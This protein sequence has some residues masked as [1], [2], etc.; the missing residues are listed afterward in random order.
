MWPTYA[1][2]LNANNQGHPGTGNERIFY[3]LLQAYKTKE[4][5]KYDIVIVQWSGHNRFDYLTKHGWTESDGAI[6]LS[7]KNKHLWRNLKS[8]YNTDYELEK[9]MNYVISADAILKQLPIKK[10][11]TSMN[12][13]KTD[14]IDYNDLLSRYKG[15]YEFTSGADWTNA[16]FVDFHPTVIQ[17]LD[18]AKVI[19]KKFNFT[20]SD[21]VISKCNTIHKDII[22]NKNFNKCLQY[23]L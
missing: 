6:M 14:L 23:T 21:N 22:D 16:S 7:S 19:A 15:D 2:I 18:L 12:F 5:H 8:Y 4:L 10:F 3:N 9:T 13:L 11:F 17:H 20:I 1:H